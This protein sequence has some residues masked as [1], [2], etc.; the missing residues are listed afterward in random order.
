MLDVA[1][2]NEGND[3]LSGVDWERLATN[4]VTAAI[5]HSPNADYETQSAVY[6]IAVKLTDDKEVQALN[7]DY[8]D[9][10]KPTNVLSFP[11]VQSDLLEA[12]GNTDD[13]EVLLGD[14]VLAAGVCIQEAG[15]KGISVADHAAHLIVHG[16]FHLLGYDHMESLDAEAMEALEIRAL[17]SMGLA[18]PYSD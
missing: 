16:T 17:A 6:E 13:G 15:A 2:I 4:A 8:R 18:N 3:W 11:M 7:R 10:D 5:R 1:L 14:I 9:K 12:M